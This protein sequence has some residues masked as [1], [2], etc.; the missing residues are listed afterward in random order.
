MRGQVVERPGGAVLPAG[1]AVPFKGLDSAD[2]LASA[3]RLSA[4]PLRAHRGIGR[5]N[6]LTEE[7]GVEAIIHPGFYVGGPN[8]AI[9][10]RAKRSGGREDRASAPGIRGRCGSWHA[11]HPPV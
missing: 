2:V 9:A 6:G 5:Q 1:S 10:S 4:C 11:L 3:Q 7:G 8:A